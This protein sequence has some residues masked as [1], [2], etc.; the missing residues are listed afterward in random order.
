MSAIRP[1]LAKAHSRR[2]ADVYLLLGWRLETEFYAP[3]DDEPY[4]Y[5]FVWPSQE[6]AAYP[7][8]SQFDDLG[9]NTGGR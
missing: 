1:F 8:W 6:P 7:D 3:G 9:P 4:E 2:V 5:L